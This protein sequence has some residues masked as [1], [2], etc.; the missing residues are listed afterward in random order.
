MITAPVQLIFHSLDLFLVTR[1]RTNSTQAQLPAAAATPPNGAATPA[2]STAATTKAKR[3]SDTTPSHRTP[4]GNG[5]GGGQRARAAHGGGGGASHA[6][7]QRAADDSEARLLGAMP[8]SLASPSASVS[9][10]AFRERG[11]VQTE[12]SCC[13]F[14][15]RK[16]PFTNAD[17]MESSIRDLE[18]FASSAKRR[19][20]DL[21]ASPL[22][23]AAAG[24]GAA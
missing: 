6:P 1:H 5:A 2:P 24:A 21:V 23:A 9:M 19:L 11:V 7:V 14:H 22:P 3:P 4:A 15:D 12:C 17:E 20:T 8:P 18:G 13:A 16:L 10:H